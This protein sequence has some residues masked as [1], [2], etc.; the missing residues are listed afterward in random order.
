MQSNE[1]KHT[2][3]PWE[4]AA[5]FVDDKAMA[6]MTE[7]GQDRHS[8]CEAFGPNAYANARLIAA[9]PGLLE[10]LQEC[11]E[12]LNLLASRAGI[13]TEDAAP[14]S[15]AEDF[16]ALSALRSARSAI[17]KAEGRKEGTSHE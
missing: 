2:P 8:I 14:R 10:A 12:A 7:D 13:Q 16:G 3:G 6:Y 4:T 5:T 17:N 15:D 11:A 9:A 1:T